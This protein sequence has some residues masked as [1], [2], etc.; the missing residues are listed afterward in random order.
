MD[1]HVKEGGDSLD[2][3]IRHNITLLIIVVC[4]LIMIVGITGLPDKQ[5]R[6]MKVNNEQLPKFVDANNIEIIWDVSGSMWGKVADDR[7]YLRS[8][9][10]LVDIINSIPNNVNVGLRVFGNKNSNMEPTQLAIKAGKNNRVKLLEK[11]RNLKPAGKS[12]IGKALQEAS[13]DLINLEGNKHVLLLTDGVDTGSVMPEK[14][15][16]KLYNENIRVHVLK[17]GN[18]EDKLDIKLKSIARLGGGKYFTYF[19]RN[20]VIPTMNLSTD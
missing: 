2:M 13:K 12:P 4:L 15:S 1:K 17:I 18:P 10:V 14:V 20:K 11:V 9:K 6:E 7:K 16:N 3:R 8:K 19:D 5:V